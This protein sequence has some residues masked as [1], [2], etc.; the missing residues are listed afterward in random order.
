MKI[1]VLLYV[2]FNF[3]DMCVLI[4]SIKEYFII[5]LDL[6]HWWPSLVAHACITRS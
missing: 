3:I 5:D 1:A 2:N 4:D 6:I